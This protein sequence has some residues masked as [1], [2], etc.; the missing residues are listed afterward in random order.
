MYH[1]FNV[2][3]D[4]S[5]KEEKIFFYKLIQGQNTKEYTSVLINDYATKTIGS[6]LFDFI[7][8]NFSCKKLFVN[9]LV[10]IV[11]KLYCMIIFLIEYVILIIHL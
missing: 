5:T 9:L 8:Q 4:D 7:S 11:L 6:F 1:L 3:F 10:I 2:L